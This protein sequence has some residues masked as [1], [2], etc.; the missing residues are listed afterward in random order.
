[1][2]SYTR[3]AE[4][5]IL[6]GGILGIVIALVSLTMVPFMAGVLGYGYGIMWQFGGMMGT[7]GIFGYPQFGFA[8][9]SSVMVVWSLLGLA[10]AMLSIFCGLKL[11]HEHTK[12]VSFIGSIG[13]IFLLL[14]FSWLP[15]LMV[16]AG[17]V[18]L[19]FE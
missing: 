16:L 5:L 17:S 19:Y 14:T 13:G 6:L 15:G 12:K 1:L 11:R 7:Y 18:L 8:V 10:G 3:L 9:M 4:V 2:S